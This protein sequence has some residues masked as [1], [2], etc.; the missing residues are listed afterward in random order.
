VPAKEQLAS[1]ILGYT[2]SAALAFWD[3]YLKNAANAKEY[4]QS[5][6]LTSFSKGAARI[7]A[8]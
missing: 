8:R 6:G 7:S 5:G 1:D 2:N 3:A 4:L